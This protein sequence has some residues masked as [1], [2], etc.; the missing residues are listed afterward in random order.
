[1]TG[2][3]ESEPDYGADTDL[4]A[5]ADGTLQPD[6]IPA[7]EARLARDPDA[8]DA[9]ASWRHHA[10]LL[11]EATLQADDL[12]VNLRIA[13]LE[14][15]LGGALLA[16]RRR[17]HLFGPGLRRIAAGIAIFGA[18]WVANGQFAA[19]MN[20]AG[21]YPLYAELSFANHYASTRATPAIAEFG[22][23]EMDSA[24]LWMSQK[25]QRK[26]ESPDLKRLGYEVEMARLVEY[27]GGPLALF[28]LRGPDGNSVTVSMSPHPEDQADHELRV[29]RMSSDRMAYWTADAMDYS[30]IGD[31]NPSLITTLAA[32]VH[33]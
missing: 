25:M 29:V 18:G 13:S 12:P 26:I 33:K 10:N 24:L 2:K 8:R 20:D 6:R 30:V 23:A 27:E 5:Y 9:V 32:A 28:L 7:V 16:R 11:Y 19:Q 21:P 17:D 22:P 31:V 1:M 15:E 4:I 14:R 3:E